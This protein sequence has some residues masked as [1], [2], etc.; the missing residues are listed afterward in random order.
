MLVLIFFIT[1]TVLDQFYSLIEEALVNEVN[2]LFEDQVS[3]A[4]GSEQ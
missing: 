4:L 3:S 1:D 2:T